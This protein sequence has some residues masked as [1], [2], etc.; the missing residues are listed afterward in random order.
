MS[1]HFLSVL[2]GWIMGLFSPLIVDELR[3]GRNRI[4]IESA[5]RRELEELRLKLLGLIYLTRM[6]LGTFDKDLLN[7]ML[8][9]AKKYKGAHVSLPF[10]KGL[11][12]MSTLNDG[13][14]KAYV[15]AESSS[16]AGLSMKKYSVPYLESKMDQLGLFPEKFQSGLLSIKMHLELINQEIDTARF[17]MEKTFD[18]SMDADNQEIIKANLR[19]RY[20]FAA[21]GA[22]TTVNLINNLEG[23]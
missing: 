17:Y 2:L 5:I 14:F 10:S 6:R 16:P 7:W 3:K 15:A 11:E 12:V 4:E 9:I 20:Q 22:K 21:D 13:K 23:M 18:A 19:G 8:P 1:E